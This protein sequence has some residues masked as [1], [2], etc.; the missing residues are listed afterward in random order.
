V[1]YVYQLSNPS[2]FKIKKLIIKIKQKENEENKEN[3][4]DKTIRKEAK[5]T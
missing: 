5:M 3:E 2:N 1:L 4:K